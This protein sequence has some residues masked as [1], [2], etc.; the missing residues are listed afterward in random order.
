[1]L[2]PRQVASILM[3]L[4][5][6]TSMH[7][8]VNSTVISKTNTLQLI[9]QA[10]EIF[11][12]E[13]TVV[14][15]EGDFV[16]CGDIH[17]TVDI[18][19]DIFSKKGYPPTTKYVFLGDYVDRGRNSVS[20]ILIL[21][22]LKCLFPDCI[23]LVR[24]NHECHALTSVYGFRNELLTKYDNDVYEHIIKVF[25]EMPLVV[26]V[27][28]K[29]LAH[30]GFPTSFLK[31]DE[32]EKSNKPQEFSYDD[33]FADIVWNDP[34]PAVQYLSASPR[35]MGH[36]FGPKALSRYLSENDCDLLIRSHEFVQNGFNRPFGESNGLE[37]AVLTIFSAMDYCGSGNSSAIAVIKDNDVSVDVFKF[38]EE[39]PKTV[40]PKEIMSYFPSPSTHQTPQIPSF[41]PHIS[42]NLYSC[43]YQMA[44][45]IQ[46][47]TFN[48]IPQI[49]TTNQATHS[50]RAKVTP[51]TNPTTPQQ[52][53]YPFN[54]FYNFLAF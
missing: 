47:T 19:M 39:R 24:G 3:K 32:L 25:Y 51:N 26:V 29:M 30:A 48:N 33:T 43:G 16:V 27:G 41:T 50:V 18:L 37:S 36:C 10:M 46:Q 15:L 7:A 28:K 34:V 13:K 4:L 17:G 22:A 45:P 23:Y 5:S 20:V 40:L 49:L 6:A 8:C 52:N 14:R 53:L 9:N 2:T 21:F 42:P 1:M 35:G 11:S 54:T 44:P 31:L 12:K 38:G